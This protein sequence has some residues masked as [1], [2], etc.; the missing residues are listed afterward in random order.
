MSIVTVVIALVA[1]V[2]AWK[3]LAGMIKL[4]VIAVIVVVTLYLLS[5]GTV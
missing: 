1:I 5:Q 4:G 2:V 3:V